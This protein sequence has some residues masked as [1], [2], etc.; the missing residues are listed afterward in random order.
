MPNSP[1]T[2]LTSSVLSARTGILGYD[3]ELIQV[4]EVL[5]H[6]FPGISIMGCSK[7]I[8]S[9]VAA[10]AIDT[11]APQIGNYILEHGTGTLE[12]GTASEKPEELVEEDFNT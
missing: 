3:V 2:F 10:R 4:Y 5:N 11:H 8:T 12:L 6:L 9:G 7:A 1:R